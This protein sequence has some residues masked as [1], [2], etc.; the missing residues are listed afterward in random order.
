MYDYLHGK[1]A[2]ANFFLYQGLEGA[3]GQFEQCTTDTVDSTYSM[4]VR[5]RTVPAQHSPGLC[6][7]SV[8]C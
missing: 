3:G 2:E 8:T 5:P 6:I 4:Q 1:L 7:D